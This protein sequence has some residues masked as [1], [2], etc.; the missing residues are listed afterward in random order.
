MMPK[1][2]FGVRPPLRLRP[3]AMIVAEPRPTHRME[4]DQRDRMMGM[5]HN[6]KF[7]GAT[8]RLGSRRPR[9]RRP[10][11]LVGPLTGLGRG[12]PTDELA[13]RSAS[14]PRIGISGDPLRTTTIASAGRGIRPSWCR[15]APRRRNEWLPFGVALPIAQT[16]GERRM[17]MTH[18]C[19]ELLPMQTAMGWDAST[20]RMSTLVSPRP[21]RVT[22]RVSGIR[23]GQ[24][25][26]E[27][28]TYSTC[29]GKEF[30]PQ[31]A[32]T[33]VSWAPAQGIPLPR[34]A[35]RRGLAN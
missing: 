23:H 3:L 18:R 13:H 2:H 34:L 6:A 25:K 15:G 35:W 33:E 1:L 21:Q 22:E 29:M 31:L 32:R 7:E 11:Q 4:Q 30:M 10:R 27:K 14:M 5:R 8:T 20:G 24:L 26:T 12:A 16:V 9:A 28:F 19:M 17:I